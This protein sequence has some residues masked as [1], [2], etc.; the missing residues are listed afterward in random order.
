[1]CSPFLPLHPL[2]FFLSFL[3]LLPPASLLPHGGIIHIFFIIFATPSFASHR[4]RLIV[5]LPRSYVI[6]SL[7]LWFMLTPCPSSLILSL[8]FL[9]SP[10]LLSSHFHHS[11]HSYLLIMFVVPHSLLIFF[12]GDIEY[13]LFLLPFSVSFCLFFLIHFLCI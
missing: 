4:S 7:C 10:L 8:A 5:I 1:M 11:W 12:Y 6:L 13:F 9:A 3:R 2:S